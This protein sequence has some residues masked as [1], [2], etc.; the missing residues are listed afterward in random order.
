[1]PIF[2]VQILPESEIKNI[3]KIK[4]IFYQ[5]IHWDKLMQRDVIQCKKC[6]HIRHTATNYHTDTD[7]LNVMLNIGNTAVFRVHK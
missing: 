4:Y 7:M 1:L 5:L 2:I 3:K 6:Q